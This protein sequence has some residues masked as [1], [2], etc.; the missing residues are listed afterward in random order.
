M[1]NEEE[2][3]GEESKHSEDYDIENSQAALNRNIQGMNRGEK[4][5]PKTAKTNIDDNNVFYKRPTPVNAGYKSSSRDKPTEKN[6]G[7]HDDDD[8]LYAVGMR[9]ERMSKTITVDEAT[10]N[11]RGGS[12]KRTRTL[13]GVE[14]ENNAS[15]Q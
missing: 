6:M 13:N 12:F 9:N 8:E 11:N 7:V 1:T 3:Y 10:T 14:E 2:D 5:R 15:E 4:P